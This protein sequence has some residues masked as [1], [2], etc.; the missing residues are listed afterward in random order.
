VFLNLRRTTHE[1]RKLPLCKQLSF[2]VL[3]SFL[4]VEERNI[5]TGMWERIKLG[6]LPWLNAFG[7]IPWGRDASKYT[8]K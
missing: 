7:F 1:Y 2:Y 3:H 8:Q 6:E 5:S 4:F